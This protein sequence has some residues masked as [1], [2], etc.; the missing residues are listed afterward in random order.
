MAGR[1]ARGP[2]VSSRAARAVFLQGCR[3][4]ALRQEVIPAESPPRAREPPAETQGC[5]APCSP[6][7]DEAADVLRF[8][9][10]A[11]ACLL[12]SA[13]SK[14]LGQ[15]E[16]PHHSLLQLEASE[17]ETEA[18]SGEGT[19]PRPHG[20]VPGRISASYLAPVLLRGFFPECSS[21]HY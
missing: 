20:G 3:G 18:R 4:D 10:G 1:W 17:T 6:W 5:A 12:L 7:F 13:E 11:I 16:P 8:V 21:V 9:P 15:N 19:L 14:G 2:A